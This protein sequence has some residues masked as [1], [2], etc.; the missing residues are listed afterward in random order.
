MPIPEARQVASEVCKEN[1]F[2]WKNIPPSIST[3]I[4]RK[5]SNKRIL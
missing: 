4:Q 3:K 5:K 2:A 1:K